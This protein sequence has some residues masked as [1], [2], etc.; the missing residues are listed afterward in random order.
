MTE[1]SATALIAIEPEE[2]K[3]PPEKNLIKAH[4]LLSRFGGISSQT[5]WRYVKDPNLGFPK[6]LYICG[7]RY[8][9]SG[10]ID[11]FINRQRG[12]A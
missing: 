6:P 10:E 12:A 5:L 9:V 4:S 11:D 1:T 7:T 2:P 8:W 3:K